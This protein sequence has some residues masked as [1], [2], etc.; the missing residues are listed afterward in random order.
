MKVYVKFFVFFLTIASYMSCSS[1]FL[2]RDE[3]IYAPGAKLM[4]KNLRKASLRNTPY[5]GHQDALLYGQDWWIDEYDSVY[6]KSDIY[7]VLNKY[8]FVLG[9][10]LSGIELGRDRNFDGCLFRQM[11]EAA[12]A[13]HKRGGIITVSWHMNNLLTKGNAWDCSSDNVV[14]K[15][16]QDSIMQNVFFK[17]LERG[18]IFLN[19]IVDEDGNRIP[20]LFRP[21]HECNI[22]AFWWSGNACAETDYKELWKLTFNYYVKKK[23]M[24]QLIWVYSPY[25]I[26]S[27]N[28]LLARYPGD[29]YV[30]I[31]GYEKY[32]SMD[33]SFSDGAARFA[34]EVSK[35]IDVTRDFSDKRGK[36]VAI[37]ETGFVGIPY[38][39]WWTN[40]LGKAILGKQ[41]AYIH[42]WR[43]SKSK[44]HYHAPCPKTSS[45]NEDFSRFLQQN[46]I[47]LLK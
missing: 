7:S 41:I 19:S 22:N 24:F 2:L 42:L 21:W 6:L 38:D 46:N 40:A 33:T 1:L 15:I 44:S 11:R 9:L 18:A 16:L 34:D 23:K 25:N 35:G 13:H 27:A 4:L 31:I 3:R 47:I 17:S 43:N 5:L 30:D 10:D 32:Q 36:I 12:I 39:F 8:P 28:E 29:E 26:K 37:T 14:K 20:L 45:S